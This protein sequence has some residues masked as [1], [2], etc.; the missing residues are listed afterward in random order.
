MGVGDNIGASAILHVEMI[1]KEKV[2]M[3]NYGV[4]EISY[5]NRKSVKINN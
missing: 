1:G 4:F 2:K 3:V 5:L